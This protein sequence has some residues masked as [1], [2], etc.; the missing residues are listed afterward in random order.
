MK[1]LAEM[2]SMRYDEW[3]RCWTCPAVV[4]VLRIQLIILFSIRIKNNKIFITQ[5]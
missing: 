2:S 1:D 5:H 3:I 4:K